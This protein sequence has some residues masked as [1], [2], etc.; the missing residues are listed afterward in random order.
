MMDLK[1]FNKLMK[2]AKDAV[3]DEK[4][5]SYRF[6]AYQVVLGKLL[7]GNVNIKNF[8]D[9]SKK[10]TLKIK[11]ETQ[12]ITNNQE[13]KSELAK[14]CNISTQA[15]DDIFYIK[16]DLVQLLVPIPGKE[17][18]KQKTAVQCILTFYDVVL[19]K[20]VM[21]SSLLNKCLSSSGIPIIHLARN[22]RKYAT[23]IIGIIGKGRGKVIEYKIT[24]PGKVSSFEIIKKLSDGVEI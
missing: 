10:E 16:N 14:Q 20:E 18:I 4:D 11:T 8:G 21:E 19:G 6:S 22:L 15:L 3:K 1:K 5:D 23:G 2:I 13:K 7:D 24:G 9:D 17:S 12:S